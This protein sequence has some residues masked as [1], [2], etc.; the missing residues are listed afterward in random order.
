MACNIMGGAA[1]LGGGASKA[2]MWKQRWKVIKRGFRAYEYDQTKSGLVCKDFYTT[3]FCKNINMEQE[4]VID[5]F[6][7]GVSEQED[8]LDEFVCCLV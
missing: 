3:A 6:L 5:A 2:S 4:P 8:E 7:Q 1:L